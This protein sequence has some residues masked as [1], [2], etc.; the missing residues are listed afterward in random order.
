MTRCLILLLA[1]VAAPLAAQAQ[2]ILLVAKPGVVDP[3]FRETVV[4]VTRAPDESTVGVILNR[5]T[6]KSVSDLVGAWSFR[7][8]LY[9]GGPVLP[10]VVVALFAAQ[11]PPSDAAFTVLPD[12][13]LTLHPKNIETLLAHPGERVRLF[14]GFSGWAPRQLEAEMER[15]DWYAVRA[16]ESVLFRKDT[17]GLWRE[18]VEQAR[19]PRTA[20]MPQR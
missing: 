18:L 4:L 11:N 7:E 17:S 3:S 1:L 20:L 10:D 9:A 15:D 13:Y 8:P 6:Q 14:A 5:P 2:A 19:G 12:V 16:S